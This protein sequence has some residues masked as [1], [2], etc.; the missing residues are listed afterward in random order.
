MLRSNSWLQIVL[1]IFL[2]SASGCK[3]RSD[4]DSF[5]RKIVE[6]LHANISTIYPN[7]LYIQYSMEGKYIADSIVITDLQGN[8]KQ[9]K[10]VMSRPR[11]VMRFSDINC[12]TCVEQEMKN[13]RNFFPPPKSDNIMILATYRSVADLLK[14]KRINAIDFELYAISANQLPLAGEQISAPYMFV[15]DK[16]FQ[17]KFPFVP[18]KEFP[19]CSQSYY[20]ALLESNIF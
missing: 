3:E 5:N 16:S 1:F 14:F 8:S 11:L 7:N 6:D 13:L 19:D 20:K 17:V 10:D 15:I 12:N 2:Y 9:L 4:A 18:S